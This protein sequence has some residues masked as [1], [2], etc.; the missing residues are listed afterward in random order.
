MDLFR[1]TFAGTIVNFVTHG[2]ALPYPEQSTGFRAPEYFCPEWQAA[3]PDAFRRPSTSSEQT[4][5]GDTQPQEKGKEKRQENVQPEEAEKGLDPNLVTWYGPDDPENPRNWSSAKKAFVTS[6]L[7]LL[8]FSIYI[9]SS[10]YTAGL[11]DLTQRFHVSQ[12]A[13]TLGLTLFVLGYGVGP[14]FLAPLSEIP[15]LG[16]NFIYIITLLI[17]VCLQVPTALAN[18]LGTLLPLRFLAGFF[19][20]PCLATG[21]ASLADMYIPAKRAYAIGIWGIA[22]VCGPVLGPLLGGF[23]ADAESWRW[24]IWILLWLSG[25]ALAILVFTLPETSAAHILVKRARRLRKLTGNEK[26]RTEGEME[27]AEMSARE[28]AMMTLVRP[29]VLSVKE[30]IVFFLN[31]YIALVYGLLYLWFEAFPIVFVENHGFNLGQE[32]LAFLGIFV[33]SILSYAG[34]CIYCYFWLEKQFEQG[35]MEVVPEK[36]LPPAFVGGIALPICMFWF[37]WTASASIPWIVPIIGSA[38]FGIGA[39]L[40]FQAVL[41]YLGDAY[42]RYAASV[43]AGNDLFR[44]G[45]G[46]AFPLFANA[47]FKNLGGPGGVAWAST[48]IG[49]LAVVMIP[50]PWVLWKYGA[51]IRKLSK[52]AD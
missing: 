36:R 35:G 29:F 48:L 6:Q 17:F 47:M 33:G 25:G 37:G 13:A 3:H 26:L 43:L 51:R 44:A 42:P 46:A 14:M 45:F 2:K 39:F 4:T 49:L 11:V 24:T 7:C 41:N 15:A 31:L 30:P 10:I 32:G 38:F 20:S 40:L 50:I 12:V 22:A 21:G 19:G 1:E 8:T 9:G 27:Q 16:R 18:N 23:A 28:V 34:F 5:I 52:Y